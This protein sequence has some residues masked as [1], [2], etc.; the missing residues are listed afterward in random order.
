MTTFNTGSY[1][2][3]VTQRDV[4]MAAPGY[5]DDDEPEDSRS[6]LCDACGSEGRV[7]RSHSG[8]PNDP[9][10]IDCGPC[11]VCEER[12]LVAGEPIEL[13][14]LDPLVPA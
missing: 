8:H 1:P 14:D 2:P 3:G 13:E 5:W 10:T 11:P 7:Y 9:D 6:F 4:D 12:G